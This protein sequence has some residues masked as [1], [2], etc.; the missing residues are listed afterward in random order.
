MD[1]RV[2]RGE[3]RED[4]ITSFLE[5]Q[6]SQAP[7]ST[8][9]VAAL[10]SM[11]VSLALKAAGK[12]HHALFVGQWAAPFLLIGIYNK[13]VKQHGSDA[14]AEHRGADYNREAA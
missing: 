12:E 9:L 8:W 4:Q 2:R 11:V 14:T 3:I 5:K 6:T 13:M 7:S 10:G 1:H